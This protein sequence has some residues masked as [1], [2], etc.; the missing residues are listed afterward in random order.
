[1]AITLSQ[2]A[3]DASIVPSFKFILHV[4]RQANCYSE[5]FFWK[6]FE[7]CLFTNHLWFRIL[8]SQKHQLLRSYRVSPRWRRAFSQNNQTYI[9]SQ[10]KS[11]LRKFNEG[12]NHDCDSFMSDVSV[13]YKSCVS[14]L[15][16]WTTLFAEYNALTRFLCL[17]TTN[18]E[19]DE[20]M[21]L[22]SACYKFYIDEAE[23]NCLS[24]TKT[25]SSSCKK[26]INQMQFT[27]KWWNMKDVQNILQ[28]AIPLNA[29]RTDKD[30]TVLLQRYGS[31]CWSGS[32]F[33]WCRHKLKRKRNLSGW[34]S[35]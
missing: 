21:W 25:C 22:V 9:S 13:L 23:V 7:R 14:H 11:A 17:Q 34:T 4:H 31:L 16:E 15:A 24:N 12:K 35:F 30:C 8:R 28:L 27:V 6:F 1:V 3:K 26:S 2:H 29:S 10:L 33:P 5:T 20:I 19:K 32:I 18:W